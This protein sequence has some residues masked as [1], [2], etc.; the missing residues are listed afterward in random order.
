MNPPTHS[1]FSLRI[2]SIILFFLIVCNLL[3]LNFMIF[4][5]KTQ[6]KIQ[7]KT[8]LPNVMQNDESK[9]N[10]PQPVPSDVCTSNCVSKIYETIHQATASLSL[11]RPQS[12]TI[13][14]EPTSSDGATI[15]EVYVAF[16]SG[17]NST[18]DWTN[19]SGL[20][21]YVDNTQYGKIK[22][23]TFEA[24]LF[25]PTGNEKAYARLY[26]VTDKHPVWYSEI[27][28]EGGASQLLI[29]QPITLDDGNKLYQVQMKTSLK[30]QANITQARL[31]ITV[32]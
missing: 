12:K 9:I 27:S 24:S 1:F 18:D 25:I 28:L 32:K 19:V 17:T 16:G 14:L 5:Y 21:L 26:N 11:S 2:I 31:H 6:Q 8:L 15:K 30:Y 23:V 7:L 3:V 10:I 29:S 4:Q 22:N 13:N 20:A